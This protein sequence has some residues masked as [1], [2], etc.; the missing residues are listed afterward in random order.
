MY[1]L[2]SD[3]VGC[4]SLLSVGLISQMFIGM[5]ENVDEL[6]LGGQLAESGAPVPVQGKVKLE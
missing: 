5:E 3:I 2:P 4:L 6:C 1:H